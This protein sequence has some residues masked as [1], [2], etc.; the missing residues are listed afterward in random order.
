M[1]LVVAGPLQAFQFFQSRVAHS[2]MYRTERPH[3]VPHILGNRFTP[4]M[5]EPACQVE[6][7][8]NIVAGSIRRLQSFL[9]PLYTAL[10]VGDG[11]LTLAPCSCGR[12]DDVRKFGGLRQ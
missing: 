11:T 9:H 4:L 3:F 8:R 7:N 1:I 10:A 12:K 6:E 2:G 5:T